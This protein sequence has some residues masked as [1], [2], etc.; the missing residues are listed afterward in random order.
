[1]QRLLKPE[2]KTKSKYIQINSYYGEREIISCVNDRSDLPGKIMERIF[3]EAM[4]RHIEDREVIQNSQH[5]FTKG[6]LCLTFCDGVTTSVDKGT[7][8]DVIYLDFCKVF[9]LVRY[10]IFSKLE[11]DGMMEGLFSG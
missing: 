11:R 10:N 5:D 8:T 3:L 1:M 6:K 9:D 4:L 2:D 7:A